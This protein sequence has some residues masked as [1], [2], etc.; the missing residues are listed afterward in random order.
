MLLLWRFCMFRKLLFL[1]IFGFFLSSIQAQEEKMPS[2]SMYHSLDF[3]VKKIKRVHRKTL[4]GIPKNFALAMIEARQK[5]RK[6]LFPSEFLCVLN[7]MLVVLKDAHSFVEV[8]TARW[9]L[10][11]PFLWTHEGMIVTKNIEAFKKGDKIRRIGGRCEKE[12]LRGLR[13]VIPAEN[14][15]FIKACA[16]ERLLQYEVLNYLGMIQNHAV[17]VEVER[18]GKIIKSK[19]FLK[20]M[21]VGKKQ[22][23]WCRYT[24]FPKQSLGVFHLDKCQFD[25]KY[26]Q[27]LK[28]FMTEITKRKIDNIALD[29]RKNRGGNGLVAFAFLQYIDCDYKSFGIGQRRSREFLDQM[30]I[31]RSQSFRKFARSLRINIDADHYILPAKSVKNFILSMIP[32]VEEKLKFRGN[33]YVLTSGLTFSSACLFTILI[34]DNKLGTIVGEPT[35]NEI[36]FHGNVL[37]FDIPGTNFRLHL[38]S[39]INFRPDTNKANSFTIFPDKYVPTGKKDIELGIDRQIHWLKKHLGK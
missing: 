20:K 38:S 15:Y 28:N 21:K 30:P 17:S 18:R 25:R 6:P 10:D 32:K 39:S 16:P 9:M 11:L 26:S 37:R 33:L 34:Q 27:T 3:V 8:K 22:K 31:F 36:N 29:L 2:K 12:I 5:I 7:E 4:H 23:N 19:L 14:D 24:I 13:E 35:G 1:L